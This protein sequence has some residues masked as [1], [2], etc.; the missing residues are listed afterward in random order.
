MK[1][2][3]FL[4]FLTLVLTILVSSCNDTYGTYEFTR[5]LAGSVADTVSGKQIEEYFAG[6]PYFAPGNK[7]TRTAKYNE[8]V[9]LEENEFRRQ[10]DSV[11]DDFIISLL[12]RDSS[13]VVEMLL[14]CQ[15][16][17]QVIAVAG[18]APEKEEE[19]KND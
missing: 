11:D 14:F 17:N 18:W 13:D 8:A 6:K 16:R 12:D 3:F 4:T 2:T 5:I 7:T 1:K 9:S 15:T 10:L 19:E